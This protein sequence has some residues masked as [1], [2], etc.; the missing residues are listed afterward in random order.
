MSPTSPVPG[1]LARLHVI[2]LGGAARDVVASV[3]KVLAAGAPLLVQVRAKEGTDRARFHLAGEVVRRCHAA[4]VRC[5]VNDRA[6][7]AAAVGADGVHLGEHDLPV[8]AVRALLGAG[9]VVGAT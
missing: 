7:I 8:P 4:G 1:E 2:N 5:L 3:D 9:A 6:D